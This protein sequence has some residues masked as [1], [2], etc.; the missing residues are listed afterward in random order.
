MYY[1]ES[2]FACKISKDE[3]EA[4]IQRLARVKALLRQHYPNC[5][6]LRIVLHYTG[7]TDGSCGHC[8]N[9]RRSGGRGSQAIRLRCA[10]S[11]LSLLMPQ[12]E[13]GSSCLSSASNAAASPWWATIAIA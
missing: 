8:H 12:E 2:P 1:Q 7:G 3:R 5:L 10:G 4:H 13:T 9:P 6:P 11:L